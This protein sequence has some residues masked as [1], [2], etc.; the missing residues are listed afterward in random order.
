MQTKQDDVGREQPKRWSAQRKMEIVLR[1]LRGESLDSLSREI[2]LPASQIETWCQKA[3]HGIEESMKARDNDPLQGE[4]DAA[5]RQIGELSME[6][7]LLKKKCVKTVF[8][9]GR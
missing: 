9:T 3:I 1:H 7:E 4:L 6:I 5:M 2:G 8:L